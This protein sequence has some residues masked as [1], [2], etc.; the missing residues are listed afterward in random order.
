MP[1]V[2]FADL[3]MYYEELGQPTG[4]P[5]VFL[6]GGGGTASDPVA[7]W[8]GLFPRVVDRFRVIAV[9]HRGHGRTTNPAGFQTFDQLGDDIASFLT[10]LEVGPAHVAGISDGGVIAID[11][12]LRRPHA[13]RTITVIGANYCVDALTLG[14]AAGIEPDMIEKAVP[15][16]AKAFAAQHD[17]ANF[18]GYWKVLI[19]QIKDNNAVNP[20]WS[21]EDLARIACPTLLIAGENDPFANTDQMTVMKRSIPRAEWLIVNHAGHAV[22]HEHPDVVGARISDFL[23]RHT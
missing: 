16:A 5:V 13:V 4:P 7:G 3:H 6:H 8:A 9:D 21:H 18:P 1:Y 14:A 10:Q 23:R 19:E 15:E 22:H 2:D 12:A 11:L 17:P 20:S